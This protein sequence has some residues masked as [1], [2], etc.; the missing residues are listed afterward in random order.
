MSQVF[1][2]TTTGLVNS[3]NS[4]LHTINNPRRLHPARHPPFIW[5]CSHRRFHE[6]PHRARVL[7]HRHHRGKG[8]ASFQTKTSSLCRTFPWWETIQT[9]LSLSASRRTT[10]TVL[11]PG[12]GGSHTVPIYHGFALHHAIL[13]SAGRDF[14]GI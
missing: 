14:T 5:P 12:H 4:V 13:R 9:V 6:D 1:E 2:G 3:G 8:P 7:F 10:G 11:N